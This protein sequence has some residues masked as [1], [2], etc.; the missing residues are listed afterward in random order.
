M[1]QTL[2]IAGINHADSINLDLAQKISYQGHYDLMDL[3]RY[4]NDIPILSKDL[5]NEKSFPTAIKEIHFEIA[6]YQNVI[7]VT[8]ENNG[9]YSSFFKNVLDWLSIDDKQFFLDKN[10]VLVVAT[11]G[12]KGGQSLREFAKITLKF[13][14]AK[15]IQ[16]FGFAKYAPDLNFD[17]QIKQ[18]VDYIEELD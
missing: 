7:I 13:T 4:K 12:S 11:P 14:M 17:S 8:P 9:Y 1:N 18:I 16:D 5:L 15:T 2:V 3:N 10:I 6:K